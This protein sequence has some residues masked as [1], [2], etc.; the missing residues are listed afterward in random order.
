MKALA[1]LSGGL[2][3]TL[4]VKLILDQGINV[5][6]INFVSPFCL[7]KRGGCGA[8]EVAKQLGVQLKMI[9][10][11]QEYLNIVRR[12][13]HGYGKNMNPCLD[14]RIL[15]LK[16]AK[17]YAREIGASFIFTGEVL[18]QRPMSQRYETLM[19]IEKE[20]GL[21][22]QILRPLSAKLLPETL[23]EKKQLIKREKLLG[24]CGRSRKSQLNLIKQ[25]EIDCPCPS[26]G[27]LLTEKEF[28]AR[29]RDLFE[30]KK[31]IT[32]SDVKLLRIGRHFRFEKSKIIVGRNEMENKALLSLK[33]QADYRFE[34]LKC[35]SPVT[36]LCGQKTRGTIAKAAALT[37]Y[38]SDTKSENPAVNFGKD[39]ANQSIRVSI[40]EETEVEKLRIHSPE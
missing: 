17:K 35:G 34:I 26:G 10:I 6:A 1:L 19:L 29:L 15:M 27:C 31:R 7:C 13:K 16:K 28:A 32:L 5:V 37:A 8:P 30:N 38:Y 23:A 14:C 24:M 9:S 39:D 3:S 2:D 21:K 11:G 12:P 40:P 36:V 33:S 20:A 4:A 18:N 22:G 25:I